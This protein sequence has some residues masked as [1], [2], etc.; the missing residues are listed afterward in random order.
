MKVGFISAE[1]PP[2][3]K[4]GAA[5]S[6]S[7]IV[8]SLR[9]QGNEVDVFSFCTP[10]T[11]SSS[12]YRCVK[13]PEVRFLP[14]VLN[15]NLAVGLSSIPFREYDVIHVYG[16]A[17]LPGVVLKS[18]TPVVG[19]V[20]NYNWV[21]TDARRFLR[22]GCPSYSFMTSVRYARSYYDSV[23]YQA[24]QPL[25]EAIGKQV[26]KRASALT[27]Q[28]E[29][30]KQNLIKCGY[31]PT[32]IR[33]V[34]NILDPQFEKGHIDEEYLL[35][36]GRLAEEKGPLTLLKAY[37]DL[38]QDLREE[39]PLRIYGKGPLEADV[40]RF[41]ENENLSSVSLEYQ[42]YENLPR[43]YQSAV[44]MVHPATWPEP[45]SRTWLE[46]MA[47][48]TPVVCS[49]NPSSESVLSDVAELYDPFDAGELRD[50]LERVLRSR[51]RRV[52]MSENGKE[53]VNQ[54]RP[55]KIAE[56]YVEVYGNV[57]SS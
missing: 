28:T 9:S 13:L 27:V 2:H 56:K 12:A 57:T 17:H 32:D 11:H 25:V 22:D 20:V 39:Y 1:Y 52:E 40:R 18:P 43:T 14:D 37:A 21:C 45:F 7:L 47:T 44:L 23:V 30:M 16:P 3:G 29:G 19:T 33:V 46:A 24:G 35:F 53:S 4:G 55:D 34:P 5:K 50:T 48:G 38:P 26:A 42:E 31:S 54:Y 6:S 51:Q 49:R 10:D 15:K 41:V 8:N 36:V